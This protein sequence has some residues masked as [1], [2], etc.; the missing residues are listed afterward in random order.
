M[1]HIAGHAQSSLPSHSPQHL[2]NLMSCF[3]SPKNLYHDQK[4]AALRY[5]LKMAKMADHADGIKSFQYL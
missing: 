5:K 1:A 4:K 3:S 2:A